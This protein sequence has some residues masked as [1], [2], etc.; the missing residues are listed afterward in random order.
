MAKTKKK[1]VLESSF[2]V[3]LGASMRDAMGAI[4]DNQR[5]A[6]I[7]VDTR[8]HLYGILSAGDI[9][10]AMLSGFTLET[11][12]EKIAN[13]H[14]VTVTALARDKGK[15]EEIFA[16]ESSI[17]MLP[18]VGSKKELLDIVI[19]EPKKRKPW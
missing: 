2:V 8:G 19:R 13:T 9:R 7:L 1:N 6:V 5:G 11:P 14:P 12:I 3:S 17:T 15:D 10:R 4:T 16:K 18:V